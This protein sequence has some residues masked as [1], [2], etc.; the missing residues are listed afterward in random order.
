MDYKAI[1]KKWQAKW[2]KDKINNFDKKNNTH[3]ML[4]ENTPQIYIDK[5]GAKDLKI[6]A[7]WDI[8][9]LALHKSG[10]IPGNYHG[11]GIEVMKKVPEAIKNP[12]YIIKQNLKLVETKH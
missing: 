12:L 8:I 2:E 11:L 10:S 4:L 5:A 6:I 3:V 9:Y 7:G 1:E